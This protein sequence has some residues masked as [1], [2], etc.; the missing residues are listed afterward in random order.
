M[1][2]LNADYTLPHYGKC[3]LLTAAYTKFRRQTVA[4]VALQFIED[5]THHSDTA[6]DH[7]HHF[8]RGVVSNCWS[9]RS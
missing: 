1:E 6:R 3:V 4:A 2:G 5:E 8:P 9:F 7:Y